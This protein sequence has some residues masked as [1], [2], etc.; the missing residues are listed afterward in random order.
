[1]NHLYVLVLTLFCFH[2]TGCTIDAQL[3]RLVSNGQPSLTP[4]GGDNPGIPAISSFNVRANY[5]EGG[6][7]A[8]QLMMTNDGHLVFS[9]RLVDNVYF[10]K[11]TAQ[12]AA[13]PLHNGESQREEAYFYL[14]HSASNQGRTHILRLGNHYDSVA[15]TDHVALEK[16]NNQ[17]Q[18]DTSF[19]N[20]EILKLSLDPTI[21]FARWIGVDSSDRIY[22]AGDFIN[23]SVRDIFAARYLADG[24]PDTT[25]GTNGIV[26]TDFLTSSGEDLQDCT[27]QSNQKLVC[28]GGSNKSGRNYFTVVRYNLDG[29]LDSSFSGDGMLA[30]SFQGEFGHFDRLH[31]VVV[32]SDGI[33]YGLGRGAYSGPFVIALNSDGTR[34]NSFATNGLLALGADIAYTDHLALTS[35]EELIVLG[36][37]V[38]ADD[39]FLRLIKLFPDGTLDATFGTAGLLKLDDFKLRHPQSTLIATDLIVDDTDNIYVYGNSFST[40]SSSSLFILKLQPDGSPDGNFASAGVLWPKILVSSD[41]EIK[42]SLQDD[43]NVFI[44]G[45]M[46]QERALFL[47]KEHN[48]SLESSFGMQGHFSYYGNNYEFIEDANFVASP[49]GG[50]Y[51]SML[52]G[53]EA[54]YTSENRILKVTDSGALDTSFNGTGIV[55]VPSPEALSMGIVASDTAGNFFVLSQLWGGADADKLLITKFTSAGVLDATFGSDGQLITSLEMWPLAATF[56]NGHLLVAGNSYD[57]VYAI[58]FLSDGTLDLSFNGTGYTTFGMTSENEFMSIHLDSAQ[59][60]SL[61]YATYNAEE[62][63]ILKM[64]KDGTIDTNWGS[65]GSLAVAVPTLTML[66]ALAQD[67]LGR[68]LL[69][70]SEDY[71]KGVIVR[72][73]SDGSID[74]SFANAGYLMDAEF[75]RFKFIVPL[76]QDGILVTGEKPSGGSATDAVVVRYD[77]DGNR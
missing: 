76:A 11:I 30:D 74:T 65:G 77:K 38:G 18:R 13:A 44:L 75:L 8:R 58:R 51:I 72:L 52:V 27:I 40:T 43:D 64:D 34:N 48:G 66:T 39:I 14:V 12:G 50:L 61:F 5:P 60:I 49:S 3:I 42:R 67:S 36:S 20:G 17:G 16:L 25:Y 55:T 15:L 53:N 4:P 56:V 31:A 35:D 7:D 24:T 21:Y 71:A 73:N 54:T 26:Q 37:D 32:N 22:I 63:Y 29:S 2:I 33:I 10:K 59:N 46:F 9:S 28:V 68:W 57:D 45:T 1:M 19:N 23:G 6:A 47:S 41:E 69:A 62:K 70:G